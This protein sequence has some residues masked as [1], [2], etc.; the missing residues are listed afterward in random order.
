[1]N[2]DLYPMKIAIQEAKKCLSLGE[3]P[4]G[5]VIINKNGKI[6]SKAGNRIESE[7]DPTAH[8]EILA[9]RKATKIINS[10]RL[11]ECDIFVTIEPCAMCASAIEH[12]RLRRLYFGCEDIKS[13]AVNN[14]AKVFLNKNCHHAPEIY[15]GFYE[16]ECKSIIKSFF[17]NIRT[18]NTSN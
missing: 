4:I 14:G 12:A 15:E 17:K 9:I 3:V 7:K 6:I 5:A 16:K 18:K 11:L 10:W 8:A 13:G 2:L 1:M